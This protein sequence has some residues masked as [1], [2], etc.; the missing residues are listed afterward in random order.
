[1][2]AMRSTT[3]GI[4]RS[5]VAPV[6]LAVAFETFL[7]LVT[8]DKALMA[9]TPWQDDPFHAWISLVV[10]A[11]PMLL[12]VI[13]LRVVGVWLPWGRT[14]SEGGRQHDLV[15]A[16]LVLDAFVGSTAIDCWIAV[17]LR[18]H[19]AT[20]D[21][22]TTWLLVV[23]AAMTVATTV[24]ARLGV[25][26]LGALSRGRDGDWVGDVLPAPAA[27]WVRR[28]DRAVFLTA[29]VTAAVAIIGALAY[30]E[31]W[32]DPLLIAWALAVEVTCYYAFCVLTNAVLGFVDRPARDRRTERAVV[33]GSLAFQAAVA[34]HGQL[35]PLVGFGSPDGV[36]RLVQVTVAP[37]V[38]VF[39]VAFVMLRLTRAAPARPAR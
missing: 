30:G 8:Q 29:S 5:F 33:I 6:A 12:G 16:G 10:F 2:T 31:R 21:V 18:E 19:R 26:D 9:V 4:R 24:V 23:L 34:M 11:L 1:M 37:A 28:H 15:K 14:R 25:V 3:T 35:E 39:L 32:T 27:A 7:V 20:W 22:R 36:G 13:A 17:L 38:V